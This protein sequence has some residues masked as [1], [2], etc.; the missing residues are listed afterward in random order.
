MP[1]QQALRHRQ[2]STKC[3]PDPCRDFNQ[4]SAPAPGAQGTCSIKDLGALM[5]NHMLC[6]APVARSICLVLVDPWQHSEGMLSKISEKR[7]NGYGMLGNGAHSSLHLAGFAAGHHCF[8]DAACRSGAG[9]C[10]WL[11]PAIPAL[12]LPCLTALHTMKLCHGAF[13]RVALAMHTPY[14]QPQSS[15]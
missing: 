7:S 3:S 13:S 14:C 8:Q 9:I 15:A 11:D 4:I 12:W 2:S 1:F 5:P 10:T 6:I